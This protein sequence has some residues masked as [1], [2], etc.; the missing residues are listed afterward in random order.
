MKLRKIQQEFFVVV[1]MVNEVENVDAIDAIARV[2]ENFRKAVLLEVRRNTNRGRTGIVVAVHLESVQKYVLSLVKTAFS[3]LDPEKLSDDIASPGVVDYIA[4]IPLL[5]SNLPMA[6]LMVNDIAEKLT[7]TFR[8]PVYYFGKNAPEPQRED[9]RYYRKWNVRDFREGKDVQPDVGERYLG[10]KTGGM[11]LGSRLYY[12]TFALFLDSDELEMVREFLKAYTDYTGLSEEEREIKSHA[13]QKLRM[14]KMHVLQH[15]QTLTSR[16]PSV[17]IT[18]VLCKIRD[19]QK[20]PLYQVYDLF[21][22]AFQRL[23]IELMGMQIFGFIPM[24]VL[25]L[26]GRHYFKGKSLRLMD[27]LRFLTFALNHFRLEV[28]EPFD[29]ELQIIEWRIQHLLKSEE[30]TV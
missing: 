20:A 11:L 15:V 12:L 29:K 18:R 4:V 9:I 14:K 6:T 30:S 1:A 7:Q 24:E 19:Y 23:G 2:Q 5:I 21:D 13:L 3:V 27:D 28:G 22:K 25:V 8:I 17:D 10:A 16:I 26:S